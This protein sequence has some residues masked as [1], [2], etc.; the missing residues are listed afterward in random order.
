MD[1]LE[2][3]LLGVIPTF[4]TANLLL[5]QIPTK[6]FVLKNL[7][8]H[9]FFVQAFLILCEIFVRGLLSQVAKTYSRCP[10]NQH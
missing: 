8:A 6:Q 2:I 1:R 9:T 10:P 3:I 4:D 5:F 7:K